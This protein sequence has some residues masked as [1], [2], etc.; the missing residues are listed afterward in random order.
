MKF[1]DEVEKEKNDVVI[2]QPK[3]EFQKAGLLRS[4]GDFSIEVLD[5]IEKWLFSFPTGMTKEAFQRQI[6][7][8]EKDPAIA[9]AQLKAA[10][11]YR[12]IRKHKEEF[13]MLEKSFIECVAE[14]MMFVTI[15]GA[16]KKCE[17]YVLSAIKDLKPH[18]SVYVLDCAVLF[19]ELKSAR[20]RGTSD[21][22]ISKAQ[23]CDFLIMENL[24]QPIGYVSNVACW[25]L[26]A[27]VNAR[28]EQNKP[29]LARHNEYKNL[30]PI[31]EKCPIYSL[32]E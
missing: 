29:I 31:Y 1:F 8:L 27:L 28:V 24:A 19:A 10:H 23:K 9:L 18:G 5:A 22:L 4:V 32:G 30:K 20:E 3:V 11:G 14:G 26:I 6:D 25:A 16:K 21:D 12:V 17:K 7:H 2:Q 15:D 13:P